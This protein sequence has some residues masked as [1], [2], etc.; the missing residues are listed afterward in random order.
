MPVEDQLP[1]P[2]IRRA[3]LGNA[4]L[5][6]GAFSI[7]LRLDGL[8]LAREVAD[9]YDHYPLE[10]P[11]RLTDFQ[12]ELRRADAWRRFGRSKLKAYLD[13]HA[14]FE[15]AFRNLAVPLL[16]SI[17]N[18]SIA[19]R[20]TR[21]LLLHAAVVERH[22]KAV[23][24]PGNSGAGKSTLCAGL[25]AHGWR[26]LSDE[27]AMVRPEDGRIQP[28]PR[29]ISLKNASIELIKSELP[30]ARFS[31]I[32]TGTA[33]GSVVF[34]RAPNEAVRRAEETARPVLVIAPT[35]QSDAAVK[36]E[37]LEKAQAFM[38]LVGHS[39]NYFTLM[40]VGF[41]TLANVVETCD[42]YLLTYAKLDDAIA[43]IDRL[44][45]APSHDAKIT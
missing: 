32:Y 36:I 24:I 40:K 20:T 10:E 15:P 29:P 28:H 37:R 44:S 38:R 2:L 19:K 41:E 18:W 13:G 34:M 45:T 14:P 27:F 35:Y 12:I 7:E 21:Y 33:K 39:A 31:R 3:R 23:V 11:Y 43:A 42:H 4:I 9:L 22:G 16:E 25:L 1:E 6:I 26:L 17:I 8:D 30:E 5:K